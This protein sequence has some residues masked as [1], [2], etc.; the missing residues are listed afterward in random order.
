MPFQRLLL[1][2]CGEI[3]IRIAR[4][5]AELGLP[6]VA[7]YSQDDAASPHVRKAD[8]S[9]ALTG[10][11]PA[12]YLDIDQIVAAAL[13]AGCDALHPGYGFL[14]ENAALA[15]RCAEAGVCFV[16]PSP[17]VLELFGDKVQARALAQRCGVPVLAGTPG[18]TSVAQALDFLAAQG[19][20]GAMMIKAVAGGGG[21]GIRAVRGAG[22][23]AAAHARCGSE[24]LK[25]F[26]NG[27]VYVERLLGRARHVEVQIVGDGSG[28]AVHLGERECSLQRRHQKL[29]EVAPSPSVSPA[30]REQLCTA[31]LALARET[32]YCGVGSIEFLVELGAEGEAV[33]WTFMEANPR[34]QVEHT[35]TEVVTGVDLVQVQLRIAAGA[36]LAEVGLAEPPVPRSQAMQLRLNMETMGPGGEA[37][38]ASGTLRAIEWPGGPG[39]RVDGCAHTHTHTHTHTH[40]GRPGRARRRLRLQR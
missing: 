12:A 31:A 30:L 22:E 37:L 10:R 26:G 39:V 33:G 18:P 40:A 13:R 7:V 28:A 6:T 15:R 35:V 21:R 38:P 16:G 19:A 14:S 27:D 25:A 9:A 1:A 5:A 8:A 29:V 32:R 24:A 23:V 34:L 3:A 20:G 36:S 2:N 11:G 4:A 17:A